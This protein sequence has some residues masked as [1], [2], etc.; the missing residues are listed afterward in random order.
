VR[1]HRFLPA[2][3]GLTLF[4][5]GC[6][7]GSAAQDPGP[8]FDSAGGRTVTCMVHQPASPGSRYT[9]LQRRDNLGAD[10]SAVQHLLPA[11]GR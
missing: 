10:P 1:L 2:V 8:L 7:G 4:V 6:S 9:D 11:R 3:I 5:V